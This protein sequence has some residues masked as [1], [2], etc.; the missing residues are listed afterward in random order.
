MRIEKFERLMEYL[1]SLE[2]LKTN[3]ILRFLE[4]LFNQKPFI[5]LFDYL[6]NFVDHQSF[7][8]IINYF[9]L[10]FKLLQYF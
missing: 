5:N 7:Q 6:H 9:L 2:Q 10:N 3:D 4:F 1:Y 8:Q